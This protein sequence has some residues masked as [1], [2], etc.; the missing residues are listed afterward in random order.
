MAENVYTVKRLNNT[1]YQ[2][3]EMGRDFCYLL[4]G[5]EKALLIDCSIGT[6]DLLSVVRGITDLPII[7]AATHA[8]ADH[9]G[10]AW[11]FGEVFV[12]ESECILP[13]RLSNSQLYRNK[14]LSNRMRKAGIGK[15]DIKGYIWNSKWIPFKDGK[16]IDLGERT[17][18]AVLTPGHSIGSC[19]WV[20][21][22]EKM[23]FTGDNTCP[24]LLMKI[25]MST[26]LEE[27]LEG[28][29]KTL[30]LSKTYE[31]WCGHGE[32]KQTPEQIEHTISLVREI[33]KKHPKNEKKSR[34]AYYPERSNV[35]VVYDPKK[36][37]K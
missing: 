36:I 24:Y 8:H 31:P 12:H 27:W 20:D 6:G 23:M 26:T 5:T 2:I 17:V 29:E 35:C 16:E 19:V 10:D 18:R 30:E 13:F 37:W 4:L 7:V 1:T 15:K 14:V 21:E 32:G 33:M 28:A 11:Q 25:L 22:K 3:D 34:T 9:T